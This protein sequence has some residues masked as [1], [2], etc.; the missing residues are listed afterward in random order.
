MEEHAF[1]DEAALQTLT[2]RIQQLA[3]LV[4]E[5]KKSHAEASLVAGPSSDKS[6]Q[7]GKFTENLTDLA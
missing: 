6:D 3:V 7:L 2:G 4:E 1:L 5:M